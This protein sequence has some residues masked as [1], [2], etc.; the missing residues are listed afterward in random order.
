V[1]E[2]LNI[3]LIFVL[4]TEVTENPRG[5]MS[6]I[7]QLSEKIIGCAIEV[8]RELGPGLLESAYQQALSFVFNKYDIYFEKE[9]LMSINFQGNLIDAGYRADFIVE[10]QIILEIKSVKALL[11]IHE[12]QIMTYMRLSDIKLGLLLNFNER[13][14]VDGISRKSLL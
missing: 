12:A 9:K 7:N 14:M 13:R 1:P 2:T 10:N 5:I 8:H 3:S 4:T 6:D 11:P